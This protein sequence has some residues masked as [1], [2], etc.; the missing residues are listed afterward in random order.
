MNTKSTEYMPGWVSEDG[1]YRYRN[2][3]FEFKV[4]RMWKNQKL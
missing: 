3:T 2:G 4:R 1:A